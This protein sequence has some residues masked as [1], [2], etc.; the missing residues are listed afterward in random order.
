MFT[1]SYY[2]QWGIIQTINSN[3]TESKNVFFGRV[4]FF[5]FEG[6]NETLQSANS[7]CVISP[8]LVQYFAA[9]SVNDVIQ[10]SHLGDVLY[11]IY[12]IRIYIQYIN[13]VLT[14]LYRGRHKPAEQVTRNILLLYIYILVIYTSIDRESP[15]VYGCELST[16]IYH[17]A[18]I[19]QV[20]YR[21]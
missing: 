6:K 8:V 10:I 11:I 4:S 13:G 9:A 2:F 14:P 21:A 17:A 18:R 3:C 5:G 15:Y 19:L 20:Q 12:S 16:Y 1:H 7:I